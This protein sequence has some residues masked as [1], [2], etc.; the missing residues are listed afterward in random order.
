MQK[1]VKKGHHIWGLVLIMLGLIFFLFGSGEL[2]MS[3]LISFWGAI[4]LVLVILGVYEVWK[5][6]MPHRKK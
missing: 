4:G 2:S 1:E 3:L 5:G 6:L